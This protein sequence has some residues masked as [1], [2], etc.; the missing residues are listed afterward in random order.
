MLKE[1]N[2]RWFRAR[3]QAAAWQRWN[4]KLPH[5]RVRRSRIRDDRGR[6]IGY[7]PSIPLPE[8]P[9]PADF[10]R[11]MQLPSGRWDLVLFDDGIEAAYRLARFP[12]PSPQDVSLLSI[13]EEQIRQRYHG[14]GMS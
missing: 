13:S 3:R 9:L 6:I 10:C 12:K 5:N 11:K 8:P 7:G 14:N 1:L 2:A 4:R